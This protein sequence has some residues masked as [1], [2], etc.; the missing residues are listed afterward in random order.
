MKSFR[1]NSN[2]RNKSNVL[3]LRMKY[4]A[5]GYGVYMMLLERLADEPLLRAD[6]DYDIIAYDFHESAELIRHVIEDFDLFVID[7]DGGTFSN[8]ELMRQ[9]SPK[10]A[11][12]LREKFVDE[13]IRL[14]AKDAD[15]LKYIS[16]NH[17]SSP[18][19]IREILFTSFRERVLNSYPR[20]PM[21]NDLYHLLFTHLE[22]ISQRTF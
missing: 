3:K 13:F 7:T 5:A 15:W 6:L 14:R 1:H 10:A 8:E 4:G 22:K 12:A 2:E 19:N 20:V 9:L 17:S 21:T 18:E 11:G 16:R